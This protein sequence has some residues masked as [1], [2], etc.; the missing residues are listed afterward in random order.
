MYQSVYL[1]CG[2]HLCRADGA[3]LSSV[4]MAFFVDALRPI[5]DVRYFHIP[6][7][8]FAQS[9]LVAQAR[10]VDLVILSLGTLHYAP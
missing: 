4:G 5:L 6:F 10:K 7:W 2:G 8:L 1:S 3:H 9:F